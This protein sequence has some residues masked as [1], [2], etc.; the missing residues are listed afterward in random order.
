MNEQAISRVCG[1]MPHAI[2]SAAPVSSGNLA[3]RAM[4]SHVVIRQW[5]ARRLD[6]SV[7]DSI[8]RDAGAADDAGRFNKLL[9]PAAILAPVVTAGN[10]CRNFHYSRTLPWLDDGARI[11]PALAFDAYSSGMR[12][13]RL[14][15][16]AAVGSFLADYPA[17]VSEAKARLGSLFK[18]DE[19]PTA[20]E[21]RA[22]FGVAVRI[23]PMPDARD[24]RAEMSDEQAARVRA[25]IESATREAQALAM[26]DAWSRVQEALSRMVEKL[27]AFEPGKPG[28]RATGIFRDSLVENVRDLV[29]ILPT[30][31]LDGSG[32]MQRIADRMA[33]D[34]TTHDAGE[35]RESVAL[36][37]STADAAAS[38][39]ADVSAYLA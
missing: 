3:S 6:R 11:L 8:I 27:R 5:S 30:F 26:R 14:D 34:L 37:E 31:D 29:S 23:L 18:P 38:I 17:A 36:R 2:R 24:F 12:R 13:A 22:R 32:E 25:D 33:R 19:Y 28:E 9:I 15:F 20:E 16:D 39:L 7:T 21:V 1:L 10:A 4:L 35:L